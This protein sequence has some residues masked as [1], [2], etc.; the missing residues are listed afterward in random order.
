MWLRRHL[1]PRQQWA[2]LERGIPGLDFIDEYTR[3]YPQGPLMPHLLG[4]VDSDNRGIAGLEKRFDKHLAKGDGPLRLTIDMRV[5]HLMREELGAAMREFEAKAAAGIVMD[6]RNG[7]ILALVSLPDFDPNHPG[8]AGDD[9]RFNRATL[10]VY[11]MGSTFKVFTAA[12][13]LDAGTARMDK[14]Y[15]ATKPLQVSRFM[16]RDYHAKKR[17]LTLPE[18]FVYSSNIGAALMAQDIG[19]KRQQ[20][21]LDKLGMLDPLGVELPETGKPIS[22]STW[23]PVNTMTIGFG[24]GIAV[25]PLH[26]VNGVTATVNGGVL[27]RP[28]IVAGEHRDGTARRAAYSRNGHRKRFA[29]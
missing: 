24:H 6:A 11:E 29:S 12:M 22:P 19:G 18:V 13:A 9:E 10:G 16:I 2:L 5:Q 15:N 17:W 28:T 1:T 25:S 14:R 8:K 4:Y 26:L 20:D 21:Y 7:E 23:R 27:H 3:V